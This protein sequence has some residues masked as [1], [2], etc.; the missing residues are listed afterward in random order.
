[1]E[2]HRDFR[3]EYAPGVIQFGTGSVANLSAE[4]E[5]QGLGQALIVTGEKVGENADA[6]DPVKEG[7]GERLAGV[8]DETT[9]KKRL[10]TAARALKAARDNNADVLVALGGGS[11]LDVCKVASILSTRDD[12]PEDAGTELAQTGTITMTGD[13]PIKIIAAPTT[14]AGADLSIV[15]GV[16]ASPEHGLVDEAT[17]GGVSDKRLMP[18]AIFHDPALFA[19]TPKQ[20]LAGS[21]MNGFNKGLETIYTRHSTPITD[22]T[23]SRGIALMSEGLLELGES[24]PTES[25]LETIVEGL[26]LVQFGIGRP[27]TTTLSLIH[28]F[29]HTLR[30]GF[31]I[32]QG[33]AHA[34]ITPDALRYLFER[35]DGRRDLLADALGVADADD[36]PEAIASAVAEV[37][38]GLGLPSRLRDLDGADRSILRDIAEGTI[39]D[40]FMPN[41]PEGLDATADDIEELLEN[42]W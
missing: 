19:T 1:M 12:S 17:G 34:V 9:P 27:D 15:A 30:D 36:K 38:D 31:S 32:Q 16:S 11:S 26:I 39:A 2:P 41:V 23:A 10:S 21:A 20:I 8:F 42:A 18:T 3:F 33:I 22:A 7:L 6:I 4:L 37:R 13:N 24:E 35:V 25:V 28:A 14:L 40:G 5:Q 29:G